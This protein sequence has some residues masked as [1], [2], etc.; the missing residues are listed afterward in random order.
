MRDI[1]DY[2]RCYEGNKDD[3]F[4]KILVQ[5]RRQ[6]VLDIVEKHI[7]KSVLEIGCGEIPLFADI[8]DF[9]DMYVVE[10]ANDFYHN[11]LS[12]ANGHDNIHIIND[13][14]VKG[15]I[16]QSF[17]FIVCSGLLHEVE[18]PKD[19]LY[20]IKDNMN[21]DTIVHINV[22]NAESFHRILALKMGIIDDIT[23]MSKRNILLQQNSVFTMETLCELCQSVGL[24]V[25]DSGSLLVK[26]FTHDQMMV[27]INTGKFDGVIDGLARMTEVYQN[28]GCEIWVNCKKNENET[29]TK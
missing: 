12:L 10:P 11:A 1:E 16:N 22:P 5:Y 27:L 3:S 7:H 25:I 2:Y 26:P 23:H 4:E 6:L 17:D 24:K 18:E 13:F 8:N 9:E 28:M 14:Y 19:L 15:I 29:E 20:A 21:D